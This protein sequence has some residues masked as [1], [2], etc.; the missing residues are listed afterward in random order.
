[1]K[2]ILFIIAFVCTTYCNSQNTILNTK[3]GV[4]TMLSQVIDKEVQ[5]VDV[6][7]LKEYNAGHID[8]AINID[9]ADKNNFKKE[10]SKLDKNK[11]VYIYCHI[12]GRSNQASRVLKKLGFKKIYDYSGG[13]KDW[14]KQKTSTVK[15]AIN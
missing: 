7:S 3:I 6:R 2:Q 10:V 9:I 13:W 14:N 11:P 15:K 8:D 4:E 12:G 1:M 5:L